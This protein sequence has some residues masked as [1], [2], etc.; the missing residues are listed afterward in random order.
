MHPIT[1]VRGAIVA[2]FVLA[3]MVSVI[4]TRSAGAVWAS[5]TPLGIAFCTSCPV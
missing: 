1:T 4:L 3:I 5:T 2:A